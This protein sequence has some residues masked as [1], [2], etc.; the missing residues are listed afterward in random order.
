MEYVINYLTN[1]YDVLKEFSEGYKNSNEFNEN[2]ETYI[3]FKKK[4]KQLE[5]AIEIL[6]EKNFASDNNCEH[7]I[8]HK[9]VCAACGE[10]D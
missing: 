1:K 6:Q 9:G 3:D 2:S 7:H 4:L 10:S 8:T 5:T